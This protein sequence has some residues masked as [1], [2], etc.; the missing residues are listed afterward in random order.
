MV[1]AI[2]KILL[3]S[4]G[5]FLI[6]C[7]TLSEQDMAT[8]DEN[9]LFRIHQIVLPRFADGGTVPFSRFLS[10]YH[11]LVENRDNPLYRIY[12]NG[13]INAF[14]SYRSAVFWH[15]ANSFE[16]R[17]AAIQVSNVLIGFANDFY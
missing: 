1:T 13:F 5:L 12:W 17:N 3:T 15:G 6:S 9:E 2:K 7:A 14:R 11:V 8:L 16:A 10:H 4:I